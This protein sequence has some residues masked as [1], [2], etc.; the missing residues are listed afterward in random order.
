M[1]VKFLLKDTGI[2]AV[3]EARHELTRP[4]LA[5]PHLDMCLLVLVIAAWLEQCEGEHGRRR[6][7]SPRLAVVV[8]DDSGSGGRATGSGD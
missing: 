8:G 2:V 6:R 1:M 7:P 5:F 3:G 4:D